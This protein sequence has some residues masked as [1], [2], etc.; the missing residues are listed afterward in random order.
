MPHASCSSLPVEGN[1]FSRN[2][3]P[4][5]DAECIYRRQLIS[6]E[7]TDEKARETQ[8]RKSKGSAPHGW[9]SMTLVGGK[10]KPEGEGR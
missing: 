6:R 10:Q 3:D 2:P 7:R 5:W 8:T 1:Q 4:A 9:A